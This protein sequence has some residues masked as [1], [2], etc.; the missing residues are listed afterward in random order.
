MERPNKLKPF[1]A[2]QKALELFDLDVADLDSLLR[3][4]GLHRLI[5][6]QYASADSVALNIE[7]G[8]G[9][10]SARDFAHFLIIARGSA[11]ETAVRYRRFKPWLAN[12]VVADRVALCGAIIAILSATIGTLRSKN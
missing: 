2:Y 3:H 7:E 5:A 9:R 12:D 4:P 11:Q 10:G 6:R 8:Y 1:G